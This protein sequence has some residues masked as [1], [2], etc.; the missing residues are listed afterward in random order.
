MKSVRTLNELYRVAL[1]ENPKPNA[2]QVKRDGAYHDV[3]SEAFARMAAEIAGGLQTLGLGSRDRVAI[4]AETRL[5][6]AA[7]DCAILSAGFVVVPIYPTLAA[8]GV[9][10]VLLDSGAKA[11]V[12]STPEQAEKIA[13]FRAKRGRFPLILMEGESALTI[14]LE[15]LRERGRSAGRTALNPVAVEPEDLAT[16]IYTSGTTGL[17]KGV[18]L[19]QGNIAANVNGALTVFHLTPNDTAL[20]FLP[21]SHVFERMGGLYTMLL[22]GSTIAF[23]ES[24]DTLPKNMLEVRP[25][26]LL[27][28]PRVYEK[29]YAR[30]LDTAHRKGRVAMALFRWAERVAMGRARHRAAGGRDAKGWQY[31]VADRL[32]FRKLRQGFGGRIRFMISGGAP[33][34]KELAFFFHG[35]GLP[36]LEGYGLTETS[37]IL[38]VNTPEHFRPGSVGKPLPGVDIRIA[39]DGEILARGPNVMK[40]Y[41]NRPEAT[42]EALAGGWFH[43]GDIGQFDADGFLYITD[44]KKDLIV[45]A[46][47]KKVP[48]QPIENTLRSDRFISEAVVLGDRRPYLVALV[49]PHFNVLESY[50]REHGIEFANAEELVRNPRIQ[51]LLEERVHHHQAQSASFET[52]KKIYVLERPFELGP[53]LTPSLKVKRKEVTQRFE[54]EIAALYGE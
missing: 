26:I 5:E 3:S 17:P 19:T 54:R 21:L 45:T 48:P 9:E 44:R 29:V 53:E 4:L 11:I 41:Y 34:S 51:A 14:G 50:A 6:W 52:I 43:T 40:G 24:M 31:A 28:V 15:A 2:F 22:G 20:S 32:V 1:L 36:I 39:E 49:V 18:M 38:A 23:A 12:V 10:H 16:L 8:D 27:S 46:G 47:G 30:M 42:G 33:L 7:F 25:T 37:P 35:A 13:E